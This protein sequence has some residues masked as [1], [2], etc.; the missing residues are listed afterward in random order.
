MW[1]ELL[2]LLS[3]LTNKV[4][5]NHAYR[6]L[7]MIVLF[8]GFYFLNKL[9]LDYSLAKDEFASIRMEKKPSKLTDAYYSIVDKSDYYI[10]NSKKQD[11]EASKKTED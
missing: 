1:K 8:A 2:S 3:G 6:L 9:Y 11:R 7:V 5:P 10:M 4:E